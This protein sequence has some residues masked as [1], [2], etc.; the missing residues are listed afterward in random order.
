MT[1]QKRGAAKVFHKV[2]KKWTGEPAD[3]KKSDSAAKPRPRPFRGD[4]L[5]EVHGPDGRG[6]RTFGPRKGAQ[7]GR[8]FDTRKAAQR[9]LPIETRRPVIDKR[10][11]S[12]EVPGEPQPRLPPG[13][14]PLNPCI[15][16]FQALRLKALKHSGAY[17]DHL[18]GLTLVKLKNKHVI[19]AL[20]R[21][22]GGLT[23]ACK[24][25]RS[26]L[27]VISKFSWAEPA[28]YGMGRKGWVQARFTAQDK[29][30][31]RMLLGWLEESYAAAME[32][33]A[34]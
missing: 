9:D 20:G 28:G 33:S 30:P 26:G 7:K 23:V 2:R 15:P 5:R 18:D 31:L 12:D 4:S 1:N 32:K 10:K 29:V 8:G 6:G 34:Q 14:R 21:E 25:P 19:V 13:A 22:G 11:K 24:L 3:P 16:A 17:E 27:N